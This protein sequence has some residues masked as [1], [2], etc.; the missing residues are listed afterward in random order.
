MELS[1]IRARI[2]RLPVQICDVDKSG[3]LDIEEFTKC[4]RLNNL[5]LSEPEVKLLH[6]HFD[7][8]R[9]G[10]ISY[11][12]FLRVVRGRLAPV[13]KQ[14]VKKIFD[15][16]DK[17]AA[18]QSASRSVGC[19]RLLSVPPRDTVVQDRRRAGLPDH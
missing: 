17:C 2:V 14:I 4:C 13:R 6:G 1:P 5:G 3:Q 10:G 7:R 11:D 8:D 15:V 12:E 19:G 18:P 9:S 16:L